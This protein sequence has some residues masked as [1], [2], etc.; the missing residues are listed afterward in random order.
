MPSTMADVD[1]WEAERAELQAV[2]Q[3]T[4]LPALLR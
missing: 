3:L 4:S 2:L 1:S